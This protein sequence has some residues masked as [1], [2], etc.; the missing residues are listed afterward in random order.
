[1]R[2]LSHRDRAVPGRGCERSERVGEITRCNRA[3]T[4]CIVG[5]VRRRRIDAHRRRV[6]AEC[7]RAVTEGGCIVAGGYCLGADRGG[8]EPAGNGTYT[9]G[10]RS[11]ARGRAA[12]T[13]S[14]SREGQRNRLSPAIPPEPTAPIPVH[15]DRFR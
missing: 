2:F 7:L 4:E 14:L 12:G 5:G 10:Q 6:A 15:R 3:I 9:T 1:G 13:K 11:L 8:V